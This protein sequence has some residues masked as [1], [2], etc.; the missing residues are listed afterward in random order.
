MST[1]TLACEYESFVEALPAMS[2][3][4]IK[5]SAYFQCRGE[6]YWDKTRIL[7]EE[8]IVS[9]LKKTEAYVKNDGLIKL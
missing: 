6:D 2:L 7:E 8:R 9:L 5:G 1:N 4:L 3:D